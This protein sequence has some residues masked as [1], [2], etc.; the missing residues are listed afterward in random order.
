MQVSVTVCHTIYIKTINAFTEKKPEKQMYQNV[1]GS[2]FWLVP[3]GMTFI[4]YFI[5]WVFS[6]LYTVDMHYKT[7]ND[8]IFKSL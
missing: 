8:A 1:T 7:R 6:K 3:F 2:H 4:F 5:F